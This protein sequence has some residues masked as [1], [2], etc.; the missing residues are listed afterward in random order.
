MGVLK[1]K[2]K[3]LPL[4]LGKTVENTCINMISQ[5]LF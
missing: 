3:K 1:L 5:T 4:V 2:K